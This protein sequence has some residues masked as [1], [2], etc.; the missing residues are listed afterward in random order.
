[1]RILLH[2]GESRFQ[3]DAAF[4]AVADLSP[5]C[6]PLRPLRLCGET[7]EPGQQ[8]APRQKRVSRQ[9]AKLARAKLAVD[10]S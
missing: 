3:H 10:W 6:F 5:G 9:G 2:F 4:C 1:M 8:P 7:Q